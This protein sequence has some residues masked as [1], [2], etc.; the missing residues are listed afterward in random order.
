MDAR[1]VKLALAVSVAFN[2]FLVAGG[3][4][5]WLGVS[6]EREAARQARATRT[7]TVLEL[8]EGR[9]P[10]V[11]EAVRSRLQAVALTA[12]PDFVEARQARRDAIAMTASD[13]FEPT[14]VAGLLEQSRASEMRGRA[15]LEA[16]AVEVLSGLEPVDRKAL[17]RILARHHRRPD[18][19]TTEPNTSAR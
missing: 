15:R 4:A 11:A 6:N 5:L 7:E 3:T 12:R 2:V 17:S 18:N 1:K 10:E 14:V 19:K 13:D 16:G 8:V 9:P